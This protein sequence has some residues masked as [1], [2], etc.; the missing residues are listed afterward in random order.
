MPVIDGIVSGLDT[1]GMINAILG[2][3]EVALTIMESQLDD[4]KDAK[5]GVAGMSSRLGDI[6]TALE[7]IGTLADFSAFTASSSSDSQFGLVSNGSAIP[8]L[9]QVQVNALA[10]TETE[11]SQGFADQN[12]SFLTSGET[13]TLTVA[14][15][16]TA[17]LIDDTSNSLLGM[18]EALNKVDGVS[19]YVLDTGI[20]ADP[21]Q[22]V[23]QGTAS[24]A[25]QTISFD[26]SALTDPLALSF[27]EKTTATNSS[28]TVNDITIE[29]ATNNVTAIPGLDFDLKAVGTSPVT[30]T[31]DS[32]AEDVADKIEAVVDAYNE[33]QLYYGSKTVYNTDLGLEGPLIGDSSARRVMGQ[34]GRLFSQ[35]GAGSTLDADFKIFAQIG[36]KSNQ[37]G[38][39]ELDRDVLKDKLNTNFE[40]VAKLFTDPTGP[41][42]T[43]I[44]AI[45]DTFVDED[46]GTL[47]SRTDSIES[48]IEDAEERI[49]DKNEYLNDYADRLRARTQLIQPSP[50]P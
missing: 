1:T 23:I 29:S 30:V 2:V 21:F 32:N 47:S 8:G 24:G 9:Y 6:S 10:S 19:A 36:I 35:E 4:L 3:E 25:D 26:T 31:V 39:I 14:G 12:A 7:D 11:T 41:G 48:S 38:T 33:L 50:S 45:E 46:S 18:A 44:S 49:A 16:D 13:L 37:D 22:L 42:A 34:L 27:T 17:I 15:V 43:I 20:G 5:E 28:I 40:D